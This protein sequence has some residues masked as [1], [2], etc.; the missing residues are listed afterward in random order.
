MV[1]KWE[2]IKGSIRNDKKARDDPSLYN[3]VQSQGKDGQLHDAIQLKP[4]S[5][6]NLTLRLR[7]RWD[8]IMGLKTPQLVQR[9]VEHDGL[10]SH[11]FMFP[12]GIDIVYCSEKKF[13]RKRDGKTVVLP[14]NFRQRFEWYLQ[15]QRWNNRYAN[16]LQSL[17]DAIESDLDVDVR[18]LFFPKEMGHFVR[19]STDAAHMKKN[20]AV[21]LELVSVYNRL[22]N[23]GGE[24]YQRFSEQCAAFQKDFKLKL[25]LRNRSVANKLFTQAKA[26]LWTDVQGTGRVVTED[27]LW[28]AYQDITGQGENTSNITSFKRLSNRRSQGSVKRSRGS[29]ARLSKRRSAQQDKSQWQSE[30]KQWYNH[31]QNHQHFQVASSNQAFSALMKKVTSFAEATKRKSSSDLVEAK[32]Y[33]KLNAA[34]AKA[35]FSHLH[36]PE[37]LMGIL[38]NHKRA[39]AAGLEKARSTR[40]SRKKSPRQK[41]KSP[42]RAKSPRRKSKS[43]KRAKS[44]RRVS[45]KGKKKPARQRSGLIDPN[46]LF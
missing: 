17:K 41:S 43:P 29:S 16:R 8:R 35:G 18:D 37:R 11:H 26:R 9:A 40:Q 3:V 15:C 1:G 28:R 13:S 7:K 23:R 31:I 19:L 2:L 46:S 30:R 27:Q 20:S 32:R 24:Q 45:S 42:K 44:P 39:S 25:N 21:P 4:V 22:R 6:E 12:R 5:L 10:K 36:M 38:E 34:L 14:D 33:E